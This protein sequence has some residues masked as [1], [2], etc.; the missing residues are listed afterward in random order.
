MSDAA[1]GTWIGQ[2]RHAQHRKTEP[3][4]CFATNSGSPCW[5]AP[6]GEL[7]DR[8]P[9]I[10]STTSSDNGEFVDGAELDGRSN[11]AC[12]AQAKLIQRLGIY[13]LLPRK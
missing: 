8:Q 10:S 6:L 1:I 11:S 3:A 5:P 12:N 2:V 9:P 4:I 13:L 7:L